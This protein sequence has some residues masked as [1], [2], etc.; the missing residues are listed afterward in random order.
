MTDQRIARDHSG[1][2]IGTV[3][4]DGAVLDFSGVRIGTARADGTIVDFSEVCV[5]S[6]APAADRSETGA[7]RTRTA[8]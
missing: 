7:D 3:T 6:A 5:G 1:V 8:V 2:R 4:A